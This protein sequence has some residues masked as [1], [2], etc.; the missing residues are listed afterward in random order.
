MVGSLDHDGGTQHGAE[1]IEF[2]TAKALAGGRRGTDGAVILQQQ[3]ARVVRPPFGHVAFARAHFRQSCQPV[4]ERG[5]AAQGFPVG[6]QRLCLT[7]LDQPLQR[8]L[9]QR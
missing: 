5:Y 9:A 2:G 7:H 3:K 6:V 8:R 1:D 4:R